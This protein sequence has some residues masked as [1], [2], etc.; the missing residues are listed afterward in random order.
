MKLE[1]TLFKH[2]K[3]AFYL[4]IYFII[5][6]F[7][8]FYFINSDAPNG[9]YIVIPAFMILILPTFYLHLNYYNKCKEC[10]FELNKNEIKVLKKGETLVFYQENFKSIEF[11]MSG[12]RLAGLAIRNLP[13]ED[14]YYAKIIMNDNSEIIITSLFSHKIDE[15]LSS[16]YKKTQLI[17]I[18]DFYPIIPLS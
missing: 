10:V 7:L 6:C 12:T 8:V 9:L 11:Y 1:L 15:I 5:G 17:K 14:Y 3:A 16:F 13:F 2:L 18:K 4:I